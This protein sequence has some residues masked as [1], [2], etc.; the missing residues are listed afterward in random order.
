MRRGSAWWRRAADWGCSCS[1]FALATGV[2]IYVH[3]PLLD[4]LLI[5]A[6]AAPIAVLAN[7]IRITATAFLHV[8]A[9]SEWADFLFHNLAGWLMM[10]LALAMLWVELWL[11]LRLL[12]ERP[13]PSLAPIRVVA[14]RSDERARPSAEP[15]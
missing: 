7:V 2:A 10:P 12:V 3:R 15:R 8:T 1:F 5:V 6:S 9:G 11:L 4:K 13:Q 14:P